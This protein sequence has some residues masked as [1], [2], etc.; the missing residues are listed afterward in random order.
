MVSW[1]TGVSQILENFHEFKKNKRFKNGFLD[2]FSN[3]KMLS[4]KP[5]ELKVKVENRKASKSAKYLQRRF[6]RFW[7]YDWMKTDVLFHS[8]FV[9]NKI[10]ALQKFDFRYYSFF[11]PFKINKQM[12]ERNSWIFLNWWVHNGGFSTR[13][14]TETHGQISTSHEPRKFFLWRKDE[15]VMVRGSLVECGDMRC[16]PMRE[17][18]ESNMQ[19]FFEK[20]S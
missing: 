9:Y 4:T 8:L 12:L 5:S 1:V 15:F 13:F 10:A 20:F 2:T 6:K 14:K 17:R 7:D 19:N 18:R 3:S 11:H 16:W